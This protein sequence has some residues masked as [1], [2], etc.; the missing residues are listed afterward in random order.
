MLNARAISWS[1]GQIRIRFG[2]LGNKFS[3]S[4]IGDSIMKCLAH[5]SE[6]IGVC[7]HCGRAVCPDC[8][9]GA[10]TSRLVC[11][12]ACAEALPRGEADMQLI[13]HQAVQNAKA[14][15]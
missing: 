6:A 13:I 14:S 11:S 10:N 4:V 8:V 7:A 12:T 5:K 9:Q 15:A 2:V 1:C 3:H